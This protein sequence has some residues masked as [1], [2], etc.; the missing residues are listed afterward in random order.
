MSRIL[1]L[2]YGSKRVGVALSDPTGTLAS[3]LPYLEIQPFRKF[4]GKLKEILREKEVELIL[5]GLPRNMDGSYGPSADAV[6]D[7]VLRLKETIIAE[8]RM[9]DERLSTVQASRMLSEAGRNT[10]EQRTRVD[11]AAA[12]VLLQSFLDANPP[13]A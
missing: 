11:S 12:Q 8:I 3:P 6:R 5:I 2:D 1:A 10:R 9:V 13:S 7:F 4:L